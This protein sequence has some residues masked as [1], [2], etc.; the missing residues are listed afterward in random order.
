MAASRVGLDEGQ[1][2][3]NLSAG[4]KWCTACRGWHEHQAFG[5]NAARRDG[6]ETSCKR[7]RSA[8]Y[9]S[10]R[11]A[12]SRR[13]SRTLKARLARAARRAAVRG[14]VVSEA[15]WQKILDAYS[16][17]CAHCRQAESQSVDH[18]LPLSRGGTHTADNVV[19]SC[20]TC[21]K[22]RGN[23]LHPPL[24]PL[25]LLAYPALYRGL[26][27]TVVRLIPPTKPLIV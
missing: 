4:L 3:D 23:R 22:K 16:G 19:P 13:W 26:V 18:V 6:L 17:R 25:R 8:V 24:I 21:N 5:R 20:L 10:Q 7:G 2:R 12:A 1:Y 14:G 27:A 9:G 11:L 15:D